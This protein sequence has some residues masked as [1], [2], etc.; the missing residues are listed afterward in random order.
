[1]LDYTGFIDYILRKRKKF[2]PQ[3]DE[4]LDSRRKVTRSSNIV[5]VQK[6]VRCRKGQAVVEMAFVFL[7][8]L[9]ITL[10]SWDG[11]WI[12]YNSI[13]LNFAVKEGVRAAVSE[14]QQDPRDTAEQRAQAM[15]TALRIGN[16]SFTVNADLVDQG[17]MGQ[18]LTV[19]AN[20]TV[21]LN[22][23]MVSLLNMQSFPLTAVSQARI[24]F[25]WENLGEE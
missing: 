9:V 8:M 23:V 14:Y 15:A 5:T 22:P 17:T 6:M 24:E 19:T 3:P 21:S 20:S 18:W 10:F 1:M 13:S 11:L 4:R 2:H 25:D 16:N 7:I 12:L